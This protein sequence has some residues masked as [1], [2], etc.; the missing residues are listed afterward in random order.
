MNTVDIVEASKELGVSTR[1][2]RT[3]LKNGKLVGKIVNR[4]YEITVE[5]IRNFKEVSGGTLKAKTSNIQSTPTKQVVMVELERY[6]GLITRKTQLEAKLHEWED[7]EIKLLEYQDTNKQLKA[8]LE[9]MEAKLKEK[10]EE[11][12]F[13]WIRKCCGLD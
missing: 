7:K 13:K 12:L 5:S 8:R 2:V 3:Y 9:E 11:G 10:Q 6:E 4:K 1:T